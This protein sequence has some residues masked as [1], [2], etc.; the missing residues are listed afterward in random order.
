MIVRGVTTLPVVS[1]YRVERGIQG[2]KFA[3]KDEEST[4]R[5]AEN[6][7]VMSESRRFRTR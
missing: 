5:K 3:S 6:C 4:E 2:G 1:A 7:K